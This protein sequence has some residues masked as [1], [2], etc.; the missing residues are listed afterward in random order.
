MTEDA[1]EPKILAVPD[2]TVTPKSLTEGARHAGRL[3]LSYHQWKARALL[4]LAAIAIGIVAVAFARL[5]DL[6]IALLGRIL[7]FSLWWPWLM[8]PLGFF[9]IAWATRRFFRGAE[10]S[11]IPQTIFALRTDSGEAGVALLKVHV[12]LG[13]IFLAAGGLLCGGSIGREGPTVHVGALIA[14]SV[15]R[16]MPHG[17]ILAQRRVLILAG[18]AAGIAA[19]F[20]TPLAGVVFAIEELSKSF[21]ERASGTALTTVILAGVVA[22]ALVG[23]YTYF[24]QPIVTTPIPAFAPITWCI[25][26]TSGIAGGVFSRITL[27]SVSRLPGC[28]GRLRRRF[29]AL[30]AGLCG[31]ALAATGS[32]SGGLTYGS[33]YRQAR[34][35]LE[36]HVHLPWFYAPARALATLL[37]YLSGIPAGI[38]APSLSVGAGVGQSIADFFGY[39]PVPFAILGMCGYLAGVTQAPLTALVIVMEMTSQHAMVLP[40]MIT[41][42][43]ATAVS[44]LLSPPLYQTLARRY[45]E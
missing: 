43:V 23:D 28:L 34:S 38:L 21:E 42:A 44:R 41:A 35:V 29:P 19:A 8:A 30:F 20:N 24:G 33:G 37:S 26:I 7:A 39:S 32:L 36:A 13:R 5:A 10:G 3:F 12:V 2:S 15:A 16:W 1:P 22:I 25:A 18:G 45:A 27:A 31:L 17:S 11:G 4:W 9:A 6:A 40:L 14:H